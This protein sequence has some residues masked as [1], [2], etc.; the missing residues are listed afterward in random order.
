MK[1]TINIEA[2]GAPEAI[3]KKV[4]SFWHHLAEELQP[5]QVTGSNLS[6]GAGIVS[7]PIGGKSTLAPSGLLLR[8]VQKANKMQEDA[9]AAAQQLD[10]K[11]HT[12]KADPFLRDFTEDERRVE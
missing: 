2:D 3:A 8:N 12:G 6:L 4:S 7:V 10:E 9:I 5:A 11:V 1:V